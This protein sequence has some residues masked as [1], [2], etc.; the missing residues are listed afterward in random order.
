MRV[1]V[2]RTYT[3]DMARIWRSLD[4]EGYVVSTFKYDELPHECHSEIVDMLKAAAP[5]CIVYIGAIEQYHK[6]PVP[7]IDV[8]KSF[9]EIAPMVH[10]CPDSAETVWRP[11]LEEYERQGCFDAQIG[12]DGYKAAP[13]GVVP[14]L[15]PVDFR[16]FKP[17]PW[18]ERTTDF[19]FVGPYNGTFAT[20]V[21]RYGSSHANAKW[22]RE[23][24]YDEVAAF[25][26]DC[27]FVVN[28]AWD[29]TEQFGH[30]TPLVSDTAAAGACLIESMNDETSKWFDPKE[31]YYEYQDFKGVANIM[32]LELKEARAEAK[33][34][35]M[36]SKWNMIAPDFWDDIFFDIGLEIRK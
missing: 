10:I 17:K 18:K 8:L 1:A 7:M 24:S 32:K 27:K 16:L 36:H 33:A 3:E 26:C 14:C 20:A 13:A 6:K 12:I 19:G 15:A 21:L 25:L 29:S 11:L 34:Y 35:S 22:L 28:S 2:L 9:R 23:G 4:A 30:V 5:D 31:D